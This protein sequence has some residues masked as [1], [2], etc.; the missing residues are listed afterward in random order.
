MFDVTLSFFQGAA[1]QTFP[2]FK[3]REPKN[4]PFFVK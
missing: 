3:A 2:V 1:L 4:C